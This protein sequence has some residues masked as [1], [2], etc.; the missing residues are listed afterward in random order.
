[1][2][3]HNIFA[4][5][6]TRRDFLKQSAKGAAAVA[7]VAA[8]V[9]SLEVLLNGCATLETFTET[10]EEVDAM[11]ESHP[12]VPTVKGHCYTGWFE[13]LSGPVAAPIYLEGFRKYVGAAEVE[14]AFGRYKKL[15]GKSP[16]VFSFSDRSIIDEWFPD[17]ICKAIHNEGATPLIRYYFYAN[18]EKVA[19]GVYDHILEEFS[20]RAKDYGDSLFLV[21][22]PEVNIVGRLRNVHPWAGNSGKHFNKAYERIKKAVYKAGADNVVLGVHYMGSGAGQPIRQFELDDD[23][24]NWVGFTVY[25]VVTSSWPSRPFTEIFGD[26]YRWA[27]SRYKTKPIGLWE[28]GTTQHPGQGK[29][30]LKSFKTIKEHFPAIKLVVPAQ[31]PIMSDDKGGS[32]GSLIIGEKAQPFYREAISD[33]YFIGAGT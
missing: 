15:Y 31:Y 3:R 4:N 27:R 33:P 21:P 20:T 12:A 10:R 29:W 11:L 26:S 5:E 13:G 24:F 2:S 8:G 7:G 16:A 28:F 17:R 23:L 32:Y 14:R 18:F 22:Y 9:S 1:M 30:L 25:N 6:M 19:Q